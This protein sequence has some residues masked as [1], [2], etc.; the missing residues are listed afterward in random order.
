MKRRVLFALA[1]LLIFTAFIEAKDTTASIKKLFL[2]SSILT[3]KL[4]RDS[5]EISY[6]KMRTNIHQILNNEEYLSEET[7]KLSF[8]FD[9]T[10]S[11]SFK[12]AV[13]FEIIGESGFTFSWKKG[14][15]TQNSIPKVAFVDAG[16]SLA[17][18]F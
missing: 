18:N 6:A 15:N 12:P 16:V 3:Y 7:K 10:L 14:G 8:K 1:F 5:V 4:I 13:I 11:L 9:P 17:L 2:N